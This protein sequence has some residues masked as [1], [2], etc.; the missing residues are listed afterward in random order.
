M[1]LLY[2]ILTSYSFT[3]KQIKIHFNFT[4]KLYIYEK[5]KVTTSNEEWRSH[6]IKR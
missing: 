4:I 6:F 1:R 2:K 3:G 5:T